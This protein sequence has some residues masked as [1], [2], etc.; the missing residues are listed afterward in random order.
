MCSFPNKGSELDAYLFLQPRI[1]HAQLLLV[2]V[3]VLIRRRA[4][5][6]GADDVFERLP[7]GDVLAPDLV[8]LGAEEAV[9]RPL[10]L[11]L[12]SSRV[13]SNNAKGRSFYLKTVSKFNLGIVNS[14]P[15]RMENKMIKRG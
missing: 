3:G 10:L 5:A 6:G 2:E 1:L 9:V 8:V 7:H 4:A 15:K 12:Q 13:P 14:K 11:G